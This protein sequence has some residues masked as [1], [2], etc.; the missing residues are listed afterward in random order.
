MLANDLGALFL[1]MLDRG[2]RG[3]Y[4]VVGDEC[5]SKFEFGRQV[6]RTFGFDEQLVIPTRVADSGLQAARSPNLT[7]SNT[8]LAQDLGEPIPGV[9]TGLEKF[10]E[11]YQQKYPQKI[12]SF[13]K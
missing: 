4:H 11:Q 12:K 6:G 10:Y 13:L 9:T 1:Q 3:L 2:L 7:L 5:L 8:K